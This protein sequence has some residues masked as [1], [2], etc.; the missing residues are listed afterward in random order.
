MIHVMQKAV[1]GAPEPPPGHIT[2]F[3]SVP[4]AGW[5]V[6]ARGLLTTGAD[7]NVNLLALV[8]I[9]PEDRDTADLDF[10]GL[11]EARAVLHD[12]AKSTSH[13]EEIADPCRHGTTSRHRNTMRDHLRANE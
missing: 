5:A 10:H 6:N 13:P 9:Q 2:K 11:L 4:L 12:L 7:N 8:C 3:D 1:E